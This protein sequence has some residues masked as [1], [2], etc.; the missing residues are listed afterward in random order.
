MHLVYLLK[1][2]K[3][4]LG[5]LL[6][7]SVI[8]A[9]LLLACS[10]PPQPAPALRGIDGWINSGPLTLPELR[11]QVVLIDFWTYSC[12]N[13]IRTFPYLR[14]WHDKYSRYGL[15]II[16]VHTPEFE[17]EKDARN[18]AAAARNHRL[19][20]AIAQDNSYATWNAYGNSAWPAKYLIDKDGK[21]R[22][23][24]L[25]EG[26]YDETEGVIRDLLEETGISLEHID[27][28]LDPGPPLDDGA[29]AADPGRR[30]TR[31][32]YAG[33]NRN[34]TLPS[35]AFATLYGST[36]AYIMHQEYYQQK[37][38]DI[39]YQDLGEHF[40]HFIYLQGL[41]RNGPESVTHARST[42][43]FE[44]YVAIRFFATSVN[45]VM[46][47]EGL[48]P[49]ADAP[50]RPELV[51]GP[52]PVE[53][54]VGLLVR[55]TLDGQPLAPNQAGPDVQFDGEGHS[56]VLVQEPRLYELVELEK[57][58]SHDLQLRVNSPGLSL[59]TFTFGAYDEGP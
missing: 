35:S 2:L 11:G 43:D 31:E 9:I 17:F 23:Y 59:F 54:R 1:V 26:A 33:Y 47:A 29:Y 6:Q 50:V 39:F 3:P 36:P 44:D 52:E 58:A 38:A 49:P 27:A 41:W 45:A 19:E 5:F 8:L 16:G 15:T 22:Y 7:P 25:G 13:C 55:V 42:S 21:V 46:S 53:G 14:D 24:H 32:L 10:S 48:F 57:F 40:N 51:E 30:L 20:Y 34:E 4:R 28:N 56:F 18:V 12:V 37:D